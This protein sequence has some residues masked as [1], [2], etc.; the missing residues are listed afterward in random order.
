MSSEWVSFRV[1]KRE[2]HKKR[3]STI[4]I[5]TAFF[6]SLSPSS[7]SSFQSKE[8][9][10]S[11]LVTCVK[12]SWSPSNDGANEHERVQLKVVPASQSKW[13]AGRVEWETKVKSQWDR[14]LLETAAATKADQTLHCPLHFFYFICPFSL[15]SSSYLC[16]F[17][18]QK[19]ALDWSA[20]HPPVAS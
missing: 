5:R 11:P 18:L 2:K 12:L 15:S 9:G 4:A 1:W 6:Q 16:S 3:K 7:S 10:S 8:S 13:A 19:P 17:C 20:V 14:L